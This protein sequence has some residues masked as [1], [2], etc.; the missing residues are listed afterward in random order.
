[1]RNA[2]G[3]S[4]PKPLVRPL[5]VPQLLELVGGEPIAVVGSRDIVITSVAALDDAQPGSLAFCRYTGRRA[6]E[7]VASSR[8]SVIVVAED[9]E[10]EA[11]RCFIRV[12]EAMAWFISAL[13][14]LFPSE[15]SGG[16]HP[17]ADI[18]RAVELGEGVEIGAYAV[19]VEGA[20]IG[21]GTRIGGGSEIGANTVIGE[22]C[23]IQAN[24]TIGGAGLAAARNSAGC[25]ESFPHLGGVRIGDGVEIG[26]NSCVIRGMLKDTVIESGSKI[27]NLVNIGHNCVVGE[28]CWISPNVVL[29][30]SVMLERDVMIG[31]AASI[32]NHVCIGQGARIGLGSVVT[33]DVPAGAAV[34]G[35]PAKPLRTMRSF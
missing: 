10:E 2:I 3:P 26:P 15:P 13:R 34:F 27:A 1:M 29:C 32:N 5:S 14:S 23:V 4:F 35:V 11:D 21:A 19:I 30:G 20:W 24:C 18:G 17:T 6:T 7:A 33:K 25:Y 31:A 16:I 22:R 12:G 8:A 28:N 9:V